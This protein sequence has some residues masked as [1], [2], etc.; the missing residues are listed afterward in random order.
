MNI[1]EPQ[2]LLG[3]ITAL[4]EKLE[5]AVRE[6]KIAWALLLEKID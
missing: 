6:Q 4:R 5:K 2:V 1:S 3:K